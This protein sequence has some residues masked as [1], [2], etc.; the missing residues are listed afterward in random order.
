[1]SST[2]FENATLVLSDRLVERGALLVRGKKIDQLF[3]IPHPKVKADTRIDLK[4]AFL[5]PGFIDLHIHG[6]LNRDAMEASLNAWNIISQYHASGGTTSFALTTVASSRGDLVK[7]LDLAAKKPILKGTQLLGIHVEGPFF[8]FERRG[9]HREE[10][11]RIFD[12]KDRKFFHQYRSAITQVTLA[13]ELTNILPFIR[14]CCEWGI[15]CSAGHTNATA[16]VME[17]AFKAG[18]SEGTHLFNCMST[19]I[20]KGSFRVAG[21]VESILAEPLAFAEVIAD[22]FHVPPTMLKMAYQAKGPDRLILI[23]DAVSGAGLKIGSSFMIGDQLKAIVHKGYALTET[24]GVLAG[25]TIRMIDAVKNMVKLVGVPLHEAVRMASLTPASRLGLQKK[26]GSLQ[27]QKN[28]DLCIFDE[29]FKVLQ[30][31]QNG[32]KVFSK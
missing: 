27:K 28:A 30:T 24:D 23:T 5:A 16:D 8:S 2:L 7:V 12:E 17:Q 20:K 32:E 15:I 29:K 4:G 19:A 22:G 26:L 14:K 21:V 18:L 25:S 1:M 3:K 13:P 9:A 31:W 10:F 11:L 6:A